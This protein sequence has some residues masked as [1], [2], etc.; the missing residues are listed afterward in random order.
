MSGEAIAFGD[1]ELR[2]AAAA[3]DPALH[4]API[5]VGHPKQDAPAYGWVAGVEYADGKLTARPAQVDAAFAELV[6]AGRF[7]KVS[8]SFYKPDAAA[9]PKPGAF[10]LRH[11]G[12]LGAQ[13]PAVKGLKAI[14]FA[15][16]EDGTVTLE[17][18]D[19]M[20]RGMARVFRRLRDFLIEKF[21]I[22]DA[23]KALPSWDVDMVQEEAAQPEPAKPEPAFAE[24][25][26]S[27]EDSVKDKE[28]LAAR[29]AALAEREKTIEAG[30][31]SFAE[32][33]NARTEAE[34]RIATRESGLFLDGLIGQG[35][36]P[37]GHRD[38][39]AAFMARL[40]DGEAVEFGEGE[41]GKPVEMTPRAYLET[42]LKGMPKQVEFAELA[43]GDEGDEAT[44]SQAVADQA[45][46]YQEEMRV[47]GV[48]VST[49]AAVRHVLKGAK[50]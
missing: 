49:D 5:V 36:F 25:E 19:Y 30:E 42:F 16:G 1:A 20:D 32:K 2:A 35:K 48:T 18:G 17:F 47:K 43:G 9:N 24:P 23:D 4:E 31:A 14:E 34:R 45:V 26:P 33:E 6:G 10:Y 21:G 46:A 50:K 15:D 8:A 37:P 41:D 40:D 3:Y 22:E 13:P 39:M 11:V 38:G 29:E 27:K 7:K 44:D 28:E 12:F